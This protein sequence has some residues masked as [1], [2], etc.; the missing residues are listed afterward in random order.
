MCRANGV[1]PPPERR[2]ALFTFP[3]ATS[4]YSG[5][6]KDAGV[7]ENAHPGQQQVHLQLGHASAQTRPHS[8]PEGDRPKRVLL[9]LVLPPPQPSLRLEEVGV[10]EDVLVV[11]HAVVAQVEQRL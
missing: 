7:R 8:E 4:R 2:T 10:G 11:G 6:C 5:W 3:L 9:G 1:G